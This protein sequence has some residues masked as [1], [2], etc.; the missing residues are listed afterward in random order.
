MIDPLTKLEAKL[1]EKKAQRES[2]N[3]EIA[4]L[5][6]AAKVWRELLEGGEPGSSNGVVPP[7]SAAPSPSLPVVEIKTAKEDVRPPQDL[8]GKTIVEAATQ[9]L[10]EYD[11]ALH[12][13][14]IAHMAYGRGYQSGRDS[15][16]ETNVMSF[17]QILRR[18][19]QAGGAI[20]AIGGGMFM[21]RERARNQEAKRGQ[22]E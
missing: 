18:A 5:E 20:E 17:S 7:V 9:I 8:A 3:A 10:R 2:L 6:I 16:P 11:G 4:E 1:T 22:Q 13:R 19:A 15:D 21:L 14:A 12:Y